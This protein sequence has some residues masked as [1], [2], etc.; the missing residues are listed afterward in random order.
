MKWF[1]NAFLFIINCY[2]NPL[3]KYA[4]FRG[5]A[6]RREFFIFNLLVWIPWILLANLDYALHTTADYYEFIDGFGYGLVS[7]LYII[8]MFIPSL[9]LSVRRLHDVERSGW[10]ML[11]IFVP[12]IGQ[13]WLLACWITNSDSGENKYG[14][15]P[16]EIVTKLN[17]TNP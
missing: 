11:F 4:I 17:E 7:D 9:A 5:R 10:N 14:A 3:K 6:R 16:K 13:I 2:I 1:K 15:N 12:L 8:A